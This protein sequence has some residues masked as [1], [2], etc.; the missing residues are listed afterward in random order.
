MW[1]ATSEPFHNWSMI[2]WIGIKCR[3][4]SLRFRTIR[5]G[6]LQTTCYALFPQLW[7]MTH[8][9]TIHSHHIP[10]SPTIKFQTICF[11]G[12]TIKNN[13]DN[14][15]RVR[16]K[17]TKLISSLHLSLTHFCLIFNSLI[18]LKISCQKKWK[19]LYIP[20]ILYFLSW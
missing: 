11:F 5:W 20:K 12:G 18:I 8:C 16:M 3:L 10:S 1:E 9:H 17:F 6:T 7:F 14:N 13:D 19:F 2:G 4:L 15:L